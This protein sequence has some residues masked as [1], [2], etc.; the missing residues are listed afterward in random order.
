MEEAYASSQQQNMAIPSSMCASL[1]KS[2]GE[3]T[4]TTGLFNW[5]ST[6]YGEASRLFTEAGA[7]SQQQFDAIKDELPR[8]KVRQLG[9]VMSAADLDTMEAEYAQTQLVKLPAHVLLSTL[10][11][12]CV[13]ELSILFPQIISGLGLGSYD[14]TQK[15]LV[16][17]SVEDASPDPTLTWPWERLLDGGTYK[18][19]IRMFFHRVKT[20]GTTV[21]FMTGILS[22]EQLDAMKEQCPQLQIAHLGAAMTAAE[23]A[24]VEH[25]YKESKQVV[26]TGI[27]GL[28]GG[29]SD[30][31]VSEL[32]GVFAEMEGLISAAGRFGVGC[33]G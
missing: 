19:A 15:V 8:L 2:Y 25:G 31:A 11:A 20:D 23:Y 18:T 7:F 4:V 32:C 3:A 30:G 27:E 5:I 16:F 10:S 28:A 33:A 26:L 6:V 14:D 13:S 22:V 21:S 24:A 9:T 29:A 1:S 12:E 17:T